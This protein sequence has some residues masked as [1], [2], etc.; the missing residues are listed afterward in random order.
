L[1]AL[2]HRFRYCFCIC[3]LIL[4]QQ[5][6]VSEGVPSGYSSELI[7]AKFRDGTNVNPPEEALPPDLRDAV[8]S[9][10]QVFS[11]SEEQLRR[12][13]ANRLQLWF[14]IHLKPG[15][16]PVDFMEKLKRLS[17]VESAQFVPKP[18]PPPR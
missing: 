6:V 11:L 1:N 13:A 16:D 4:N 12:I 9:I 7:D 10:H 5:V 17:S 3:F 14:R 15:V 8:A 18:A 2:F